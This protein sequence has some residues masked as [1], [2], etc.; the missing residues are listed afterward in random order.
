MSEK[1]YSTCPDAA[2]LV[3]AIEAELD[4]AYGDAEL[5]D[6]SLRLP[7]AV[8]AAVWA[9]LRQLRAGGSGRLGNVYEVRQFCAA[10]ADLLGLD[11]ALRG[12]A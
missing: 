8:Q 7:V 12:E 4:A 3:A 1:L 9:L 6:G 2:E 5:C 11:D 10:L